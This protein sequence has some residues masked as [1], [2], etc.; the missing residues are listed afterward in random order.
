ME[1]YK[2]KTAVTKEDLTR[3]DDG[4]AV[5][6]LS[7]YDNLI[8]RKHLNV[9]RRGGG[10]G[11]Y[12]LIDYETMPERF[13]ERFEAKYGDPKAYLLR[14]QEPALVISE[15]AR[16]YYTEA[17]RA[18]G[19]HFTAE[20][21]EQY[22]LNASVL[23]HL[24]AK[25]EEQ[26]GSRRRQGTGT[27][28]VWEAICASCEQWSKE[29]HHT[30]PSRPAPLQNRIRQ[31][32]KEG[33][34]SLISRRVENNNSRKITDEGGRYLVALRRSKTPVHSIATIL[35]AYNTRAL[36]CGWELLKSTATVKLYLSRPE[37]E[38]LWYSEVYGEQAARQ[39]F[40]RKQ[41]TVMPQCRDMLWYGD[42][43]R[44]NL[45][46]KGVDRN[47]RPALCTLMVY[48]VID[49]YSEMLLGCCISR[50]ENEA[51]Q[52]RAFRMAVER[53]GCK[54]YE[55]VTDN[56]GS[57]KKAE[58]KQFMERL[59]S[60][61]RFTAPYTPQAKSIE[62]VFGRF[63]SQ[64]LQQD[65]AFSGSNMTAVRK[66][67]KPK[68]EFIAQNF[69]NLYTYEELCEAYIAY[70]EVWNS[71]PHP[72]TKISRREMYETS[73]NERAIPLNRYDYLDLFWE[74]TAQPSIY[75]SSGIEIRVDNKPYAYEVFD[76]EGV[77]DYTFNRNNIGRKF[78]VRYDRDDMT[79]VWLYEESP[80]GLRRVR[81]AAA[82]AM[83]HRA[84]G[85]QTA[86]EQD[87]LRATLDANKR[88]RL[89]RQIEGY[90]IEAEF[91]LAP[92]QNGLRTP[93]LAGLSKND[94]ERLG[95]RMLRQLPPVE[96]PQ[97][98]GEAEDEADERCE[99][100]ALGEA[101]K[102][103]SNTTIDKVQTYNML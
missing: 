19:K 92:E 101:Q 6:S 47:G 25:R 72:A 11:C 13:K 103:I 85:E 2:D 26:R 18:D 70:R 89:Q 24:V 96:A 42:G 45:Y 97:T 52:H 75:T 71:M 68:R 61:R 58:A 44:L 86:A 50:T 51:M 82:Y 36:E 90:E 12:V 32:E 74:Q 66:D 67:L 88:A 49:A 16:T 46:Y 29:L 69:E 60:V 33:Y 87:F 100:V 53:A 9:L 94:E 17:L 98:A 39:R 59:C 20:Q 76:E 79:K 80:C 23:E 21:I 57:Q 15:R 4:P 1:L 65:W 3:D 5:M 7:N 27:A 95:D 48:E 14:Q 64:V 99:P 102:Q 84:I 54:P 77:P 37:I 28:I 62:Q 8:K 78:Y 93:K 34:A 73:R 10:L 38:P 81:E 56:Q 63:Q 83:I 30:L 40:D 41:R 22:T 35:K 91:G 31:F 43:T 55:I